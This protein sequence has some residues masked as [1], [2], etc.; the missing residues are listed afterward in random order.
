VVTIEQGRTVG[1]GF[2]VAPGIVLTNR[3]VVD[4]ANSV[5]VKFSNGRTSAAYVT[6]VASDADLA[7][8]RVDAPPAPQP[9]LSLGA[10]RTAR[11][12]KE[13]L[14]IG[15]P[16]RLQGTET[17][18]NDSALR[19]VSGITLVQTDAAIN[20]GNSGGPVV[21]SNGQVVGIATMKVRAA[22]AL[23]FAIAIE[24][25]RTLMAGR[26]T[27][28][29]AD[30]RSGGDSGPTPLN[31][32]AKSAADE[33]RELGTVQFEMIVR[34]AARQAD[35]IDRYWQQYQT[36]CP[37]A[38]APRVLD[39]RDWFGIWANSSTVGT[40][41]AP[42]CPLARAELVVAASKIRDAMKAAEEAARTAGVNPGTVRD[43][44]RKHA[45]EWSNWDR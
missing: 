6:S 29:L 8:V 10:A 16:Q 43:I 17:R 38:P 5:R 13:L 41:T 4:G 39:G 19:S 36:K 22:E 44:R 23:G 11:V 14:V 2:F 21:T 18:G 27:V 7:L 3:H 28:A 9:T 35:A 12:G 24:H 33:A 37:G 40:S 20:P 25:A 32:P 42:R 26:T 15:Y 34:A 1:S 31:V 45:M 30:A